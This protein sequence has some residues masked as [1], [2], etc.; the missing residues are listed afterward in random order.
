MKKETTEY[1]RLVRMFATPPAFPASEREMKTLKEADTFTVRFD[2]WDLPCYGFG[3]GKTILL[4]HGWGS[5]AGHLTLL[6]GALARAGF[7][8]VAFDAPAHYSLPIEKNKEYS[9]MF[10][11]GRAISLVSRSLGEVYGV[12]GHSLGAMAS[13]FAMAAFPHMEDCAF[14][15][16]KLVLASTP[17]T[18]RHVLANFGQTHSL[19]AA[20]QSTL[21]E[22][23]QTTFAMAIADYDCARALQA[24]PGEKLIIQDENDEH[25]VME[26]TLARTAAP[27][28][29]RILVTQKLGHNRVLASKQV[30]AEIINFLES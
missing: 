15:C 4:C 29:A 25:F 17:A 19:S 27:G 11:I 28:S 18:T 2:D 26:E 22:E 9:N 1:S 7:R 16:R 20:E 8:A 21:E 23:L 10:E 30:F 14:S 5:R 13:L 12:F 3:Q 24:I 6:A